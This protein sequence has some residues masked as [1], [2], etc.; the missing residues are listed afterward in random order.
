MLVE[1]RFIASV[2]NTA[3]LLEVPKALSYQVDEGKPLLNGFEF[4]FICELQRYGDNRWRCL[5]WITSSKSPSY[6]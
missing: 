1:T 3:Q 6:L 4:A 5:Q 2:C